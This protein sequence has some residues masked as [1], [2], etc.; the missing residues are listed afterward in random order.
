MHRRQT[1]MKG[2]P[3]LNELDEIWGMKHAKNRGHQTIG[4]AARAN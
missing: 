4:W 2:G 3:T 1:T